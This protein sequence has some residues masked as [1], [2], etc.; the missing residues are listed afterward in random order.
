MFKYHLKRSR[1]KESGEHSPNQTRRMQA[2]AMRA[3]GASSELDVGQICRVSIP[4]PE[5]KN[6]EETTLMVFVIAKK[7]DGMY[8]LAC[9]HGVLK[10]YHY[11]SY[12]EQL[13]D[14]TMELMGLQQIYREWRAFK[15]ISIAQA[16]RAKEIASN[17]R[18]K[19]NYQSDRRTRL[20]RC[21]ST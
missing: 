18:L 13:P 16:A 3:Q 12:L 14:V 19:C 1:K 2:P 6:S 11:R 20:C 4:P 21:R 17:A 5:E 10:R 8:K 7:Q 9:K 15:E